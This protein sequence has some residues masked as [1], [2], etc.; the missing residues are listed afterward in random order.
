[1][2]YKTLSSCPQKTSYAK[3]GIEKWLWVIIELES[4]RKNVTLQVDYFFHWKHQ[5]CFAIVATAVI[6]AS[7]AKTKTIL[8]TRLRYNNS[9][10]WRKQK[11]ETGKMLCVY[12]SYCKITKT[13]ALRCRCCLMKHEIRFLLKSRGWL[14]F[15]VVW[16]KAANSAKK[17]TSAVF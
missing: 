10:D 15:F 2:W 11:K 12:F 14:L 9:H 16:N 6:K 3:C 8:L 5:T 13:C 4:C 1:M 7:Q 17:L